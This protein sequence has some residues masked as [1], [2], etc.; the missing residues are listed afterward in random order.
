[1]HWLHYNVTP[2]STPINQVECARAAIVFWFSLW[3]TQSPGP[4]DAHKTHTL[5]KKKSGKLNTA[6]SMAP[7]LKIVH[8]VWINRG[9]SQRGLGGG[10]RRPSERPPLPA[11]INTV[12][13]GT[14][15]VSP[16]VIPHTGTSV[17]VQCSDE[18]ICFCA[19]ASERVWV[20]A[21]LYVYKLVCEPLS[22]TSDAGS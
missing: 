9:W 6:Y 19:T 15:I 4:T 7:G 10:L 8:N 22:C 20:C 5:K 21:V 11:W 14:Q 3:W 17:H 13:W 1:M 18:S 2:V 16:P 12:S